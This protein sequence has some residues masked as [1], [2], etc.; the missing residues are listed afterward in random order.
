MKQFKLA[1]LE[2]TALNDKLVDVTCKARIQVIVVRLA[3]KALLFEVG[4]SD[5]VL[6]LTTVASVCV[7]HWITNAWPELDLTAQ[8]FHAF[9]FGAQ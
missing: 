5:T 7:Y 9:R 8:I 1:E 3:H 2:Q 4:I 6:N